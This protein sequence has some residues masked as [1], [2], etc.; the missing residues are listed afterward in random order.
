MIHISSSEI[1]H[2]FKQQFG[3]QCVNIIY[4]KIGHKSKMEVWYGT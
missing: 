3:T 1:Q 4:E 2:V